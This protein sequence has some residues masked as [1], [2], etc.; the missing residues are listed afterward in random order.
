[1]NSGTE[2]SPT[3]SSTSPLPM[4]C[5]PGL[6]FAQ[7]K[8]LPGFKPKRRYSPRSFVGTRASVDSLRF[9]LEYTSRK[10][11]TCAHGSGSPSSF[12]TLPA[13]TPHGIIRN[14]S[15]REF[16]PGERRISVPGSFGDFWPRSEEHTS[17]LQSLA[18]L[19]CRLLL[20]KK[21]NINDLCM[22]PH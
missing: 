13:M 19:V 11:L 20:E 7:I 4:T 21:K 16:C 18:Y 6:Y 15:P 1:M 9:P 22:Y 5:R 8:Y 3:S 10:A 14:R 2:Y 17:E 12:R